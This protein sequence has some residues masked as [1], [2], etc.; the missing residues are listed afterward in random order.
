MN[1]QPPCLCSDSGRSWIQASLSLVL[2]LGLVFAATSGCARSGKP[3]L[4]KGT[5]G[6]QMFRGDWDD[7]GAAVLVG[8]KAEEMVIV[9][10]HE[11]EDPSRTARFELGSHTVEPAE[12]VL[13]R[14]GGPLGKPGP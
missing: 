12:V 7:V 13:M 14:M 3:G 4:V 5:S 8:A 2:S 9:K 6:T 1:L 11:T 10:R